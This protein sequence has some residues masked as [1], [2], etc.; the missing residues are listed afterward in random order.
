MVDYRMKLEN[1]VCSL[2]LAKRLKELGVRQSSHFYWQ[3]KI[4]ANDP[5]VDPW[6]LNDSIDTHALENISAFTV[7]ELGEM[8]A[9][10]LFRSWKSSSGHWYCTYLPLRRGEHEEMGDTEA[11]ARARML[12]Y[13]IENSLV[14][15]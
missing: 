8:L 9:E 5:P 11:R 14:K 7:A 13:L 3:K 2:Q 12:I 4:F 15:V 10:G 6:I 1:Q